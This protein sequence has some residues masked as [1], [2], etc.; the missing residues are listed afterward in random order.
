MNTPPV[1]TELLTAIREL[2]NEAR[3][4]LQ[5]TVNHVMVKTYWEVGRLIVEHE[6]GG[7]KHATYGQSQIKLLSEKLKH[8][9]GK[10]FNQSNLRRMR[11][12]FSLSNL[13]RS[14]D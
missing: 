7:E 8:E 4:Q 12:L 5:Q 3:T 6:Q 1:A 14:A 11:V 13:V 10:G 2:L 9:F